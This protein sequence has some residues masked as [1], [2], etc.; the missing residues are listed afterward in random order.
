M[1]HLHLYIIEV[2]EVRFDL[3]R[4]GVGD[5]SLEERIVVNGIGLFHRGYI[6][7]SRI[8]E[9]RL[10]SNLAPSHKLQ[11]SI[12]TTLLTKATIVLDSMYVTSHLPEGTRLDTLTILC[13]FSKKRWHA[14]L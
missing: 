12:E 6:G 9:G 11:E 3:G 13:Q 5:I 1:E 4:E 14:W 10:H 8:S 2:E 7:V